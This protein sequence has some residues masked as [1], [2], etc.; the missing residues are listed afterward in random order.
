MRVG[1][2]GEFGLIDMLAKNLATPPSPVIVGIGDDAAVWRWSRKTSIATTDTLVENVHFRLYFTTWYDLGW[3]CIAVNL[4]DIAAM[5]GIPNYALVTIGLSRD[6]EAE[7]VGE[8]YRGMADISQQFG[9]TIIGGDTVSSPLGVFVSATVFGEATDDDEP[10]KLMLRSK[11]RV[12][13]RVCVTGFLGSSAAGLE[14]LMREQ[15]LDPHIAAV[16]LQ[17]HLRP[18][19]RLRE[20]QELAASGVEAG[21]DISDGLVGDLQKMCKLSGVGARILLDSLPIH[22]VTRRVFPARCVD[23]ALY[24]GEDYELL[25]CASNDVVAA[26]RRAFEAKGLAPITIIGEVVAGPV[27]EVTLLTEDG[28]ELKASRG[29]YDHFAEGTRR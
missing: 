18:I 12:G 25:F 3:K 2:V 20:G 1:Q 5:G 26:T 13:D 15:K 23:F 14:L 28:A 6:M 22:E 7:S 10:P 17:A 21:M 19:P 16:L 24:G 8:M 9:T 11:A 27:G 4:S 29:G